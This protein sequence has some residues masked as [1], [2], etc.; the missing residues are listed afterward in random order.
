MDSRILGTICEVRVRKIATNFRLG[1]HG[2]GHPARGTFSV[3]RERY[4]FSLQGF[5]SSSPPQPTVPEVE[6]RSF[7]AAKVKEALV[8]LGLPHKQ[9]AAAPA[10][11]AAVAA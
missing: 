7:N 1:G 8:K 2:L 4:K 9:H 3:Y 11:P 5:S 6:E 10:A